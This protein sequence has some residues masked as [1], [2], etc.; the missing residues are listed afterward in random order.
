[1]PS[2]FLDWL[3][4][5]RGWLLGG[6]LLH[7][8]ALHALFIGMPSWD[9]FTYHLPPAVEL[10]QHGSLGLDRYWVFPFQGLVPITEMVYV[11]GHAVLG[12]PSLLITGPLIVFPLCVV[13]VYKLGRKLTGT[14]HG[15]N[16]AALAYAAI[17]L[18][19][20]QPFAAY[21]DY[22]VSAALA[23][24]VYGLLE[25]RDSP[26]PWRAAIRIVIAMVIVTL[27]KSSGLYVAG[28][29][30]VPILVVLW[31]GLAR[32]RLPRR[33]LGI[34][35]VA[36]AVGAVPSLTIQIL[37][38]IHYGSPIYP[39]QL[40]ILGIK[41]GPGLAAK[42]MFRQSGLADETWLE[43]GRS[44]VAGWI[45][46]PGRPFSFYD[47]RSLGGGWVLLVALG[48]V[49][50]F[51]RSAT[52]LEKLLV[53]SCVVVSVLA[54]DF[55]YPRWSFTLTIA[56]CAVVGRAM[57][58]LARGDR[59]RWRFWLAGVVLVLHFLRPVY[60]LALL[61]KPGGIGPR[62]DVI[63][64]STF[65]WGPGA[66]API[67]DLDARFIIIE[68]TQDGFLLP[69]YGRH[70]TNEVLFTLPAGQ[71][72]PR[73]DALRF[74]VAR[75]PTAVFI[76]ELDHTQGCDRRCAIPTEWDH[77][78]GWQLFPPP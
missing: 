64:S 44:F 77:C 47:S 35:V 23:Y 54:R 28:A 29:L 13:G 37:K 6:W 56:I 48:L 9:G 33:V 41:I 53:V 38:T 5:Y 69:L 39:F 49:P 7:A 65:R 70:L 72:G 62:L 45:W 40:T 3:H 31:R 17:P 43:M 59:G 75:D 52:R 19:N 24:L 51:V 36:L 71:L 20:Q 78:R 57:P 10:I 66:F 12:L 22:I 25:L 26:R 11:P 18:I 74:V 58:E 63:G 34:A 61:H 50:A 68:Y 16:L 30:C 2:R 27:T 76:D 60:D 15:G 42:E 55:W 67:D 14:V 73:C 8:V 1:M 32:D 4:R 46:P 21:V